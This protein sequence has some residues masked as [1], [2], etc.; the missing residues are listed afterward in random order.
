MLQYS[1]V[2][3]TGKVTGAGGAGFKTI[4]VIRGKADVY[5]HVTLIKKWDIC[6]GEALLNAVGGQMKTLKNTAID[7]SKEGN[8]ANT[9]G[10]LASM[11][12]FDHYMNKLGP[13][14]T[15]ANEKH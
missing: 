10:L 12:H 3:H 13:V 9:D 15:A 4:E 1:I 2:G 6:A 8:P 5:A 11:H 14:F 7:Y